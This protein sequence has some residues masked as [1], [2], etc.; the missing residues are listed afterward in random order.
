MADGFHMD[1]NWTSWNP[2]VLR[3]LTVEATNHAAHKVVEYAQQNLDKGGH[4]DSGLL[5]GSFVIDHS[6]SILGP[7]AMV[8][9]SA[10]YAGFVDQGT[11]ERIYPRN[12]Q[13]L[14]FK[15]G[16]R[17]GHLGKRGVYN[18][19]PTGQFSSAYLYRTS[20]AGQKATNFFTDARNRLS[21]LDFL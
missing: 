16:K 6:I 8:T 5:R 10:P 9:N 1:A 11:P 7:E 4:N 14:K 18:A 15:P 2:L 17:G 21:L 19:R 12:A 20:V 13:V 3:A